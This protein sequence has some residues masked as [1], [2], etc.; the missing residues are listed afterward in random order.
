MALGLGYRGEQD[1]QHFH[2]QR[3][4]GKDL[5]ER[6][7]R[8]MEQQVQGPE[9]KPAWFVRETEKKAIVAGVKWMWR[10]SSGRGNRGQVWQGHGEDLCYSGLIKVTWKFKKVEYSNT[11]LIP[12]PWVSRD[13]TAPK[14]TVIT[15]YASCK[16]KGPEATHTSERLAKNSG[17]SMTPSGS[18]LPEQL[19]ELRQALD[20]NLQFYYKRYKSGPVKWRDT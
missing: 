18:V 10:E 7:S 1:Q 12:S 17:G 20:L 5:E 4:L 6:P 13:P 16:F 9:M 19:T 8:E 2:P 15:S 14:K 3:S 11:I